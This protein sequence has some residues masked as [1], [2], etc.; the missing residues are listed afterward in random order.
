M[1]ARYQKGSLKR[2]KRKSGYLVWIFRWRETDADGKRR[3][4]KIVVGPVSELPTES[5]ARRALQALRINVNL[6]LSEQA[7]PPRNFKTLVDHYRL[8]ELVY[9]NDERKA[10]STK[11]GYES[12]LKNWIVPR[13]GEYML[14]RMEN[15]IA[16]HVEEWLGTVIRSRGTKAKLRNIMS[17]V[18][19]HAIRYGWM[20]TNPIRAVRQSAK[21]ERIIEPLTAEELQRLFAELGPRERTLVLLDVPTGMRRG[22]VLA[23]QWCDIDFGK[24]TL[25]VRKSI[26]QQHLGPVKTEESEKVMPLDNE[27][28]ADLL[29]WR[30]E[31]PYA[32]DQDWIFAS[33]RMKGRQPLWPEAIERNY[34]RPAA[35]RAK[36]TKHISWHVFRH[37]FSTLLAENDEDV[38]TVQSLMRHANSN[39]TMNIYTHAVSSKKRRAQRKVVEMILPEGNKVVATKGVA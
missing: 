12:Y 5:D 36:I 10:Y 29:R 17:A 32:G 27:M 30:S 22:E 3:P 26:W 21:R 16:V 28:I 15:G 13:W 31:T 7:R 8:K 9:Q 2:I 14:A 24:K 25:N 34:I 33:G 20:A 39:I 11:K 4:K 35:E 1:R 23:T 6:D 38:K 37:T 19:T 18:C